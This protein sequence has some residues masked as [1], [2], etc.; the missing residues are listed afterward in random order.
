M[1]PARKAWQH[2]RADRRKFGMV[3]ACFLLGMLFWA[4]LIIITDMPRTAI[5]ESLVHE[6]SAQRGTVDRPSHNESGVTAP[7]MLDSTP[8][9]DPFAAAR[10]S[11]APSARPVAE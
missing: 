1:S 2:L 11:T 7:L 5:A 3:C 6:G 9:R 4:R 8:N 10:A